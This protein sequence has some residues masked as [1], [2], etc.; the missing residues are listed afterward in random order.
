MADPAGTASPRAPATPWR[1][2]L[3]TLAW[4][5]LVLLGCAAWVHGTLVSLRLPLAGALQVLAGTALALAASRFPIR[6][7]RTDQSFSAA[8][9]FTVLLLLLHGPAAAGLAAAAEVL[10]T[11]W[12]GKQHWTA[13]VLEATGAALAMLLCGSL[14]QWLLPQPTGHTAAVLMAA[15]IFGGLHHAARSALALTLQGLRRARAPALD[16]LVGGFGWAGIAHAATAATAALLFIERQ[17]SG[18]VVML[19][20]VA[21]VALLFTT[22]HFF[23]LQQQADDAVRQ[24]AADAIER[25][26]EL[27]ASIARERAAALKAHHLRELEQSERRFHNAFTH[28]S[29]GM[30]LLHFDGRIRQ[31]NPALH[32]LL[33]REAVALE[34]QLFGDLLSPADAA[35][36]RQEMARV[37]ARE[38]ESLSLELC[39]R[40]RD[41]SE[42]WVS[43]NSS[44]FSEPGANEPCFILQIQDISARRRAEHELRHRAFHDK[45]TGL[46]NRERFNEVLCAALAAAQV[47]PQRRFAVLFLD[48]DRFKLINDSQGHAA[49][50]EFLVRAS[51]RLHRCLRHRDTLARLGG[52][53]F[54]IL[55]D[56]LA[57]DADA[58][59]L[60]ERLLEC[61][62]EPLGLAGL[63]VT[64][65][66]SIG[67]TFSSM[68]YRSPEDMLRDAD[69]AMYRAKVDG[70]ARFALFDVRLHTE[71]SNRLRLEA[72]LRDALAQRQLT[73]AYQP[74]FELAT[75]R[76]QGF[77]ALARWNH[78]TLGPVSP[79][80]FIP[81]AEESGLVVQLTDFV[82]D[83]ACRQLRQWQRANPDFDEI[84]LHVNVAAHDVAGGGLVTRVTEALNRTGLLPR[85]LTIELTENI[86]M[87]QLASALGTLRQL[88]ELGVGLAVDDFGTGYSSLSHLSV[89]PI[90]S[91]KIDMSFVRN[92]RVGSSEA[93][94]IRAIVLL[95]TSLGKRVIAEGI[96]TRSQQEQLRDL[97][98]ELGQGF[99]LSRPL[100]PAAVPHLL[101][102]A[103]TQPVPLDPLHEHAMD[104]HIH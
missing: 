1:G 93:A 79:G 55:A 64:A 104:R 41:G 6:L 50:D 42:V 94:V 15:M 97:G 99:Y 71:V 103:P 82:L 84:S 45:L 27:A 53:E 98:C 87:T 49:G 35:L 44:L 68:G 32:A 24:A 16:E 72:D 86:L 14:L 3:A 61:L 52:D 48:F 25:E 63:A 92:L 59:V 56:D 62:R 81:I 88:R 43:A 30:A 19:A 70:K 67:I 38:T 13:P 78:P 47:D 5:T 85:H 51:G 73:V 102:A 74:L 96:E 31:A 54:A 75:G 33:G 89:L 77:E 65:S 76:L 8:S 39:C 91:L 7:S 22:L 36:L 4:Y 58:V 17:H 29:I 28:A 46:P 101:N 34:S 23:T 83:T 20:M 66:A 40:H 2:R 60:A 80:T 57:D 37:A 10:G 9:I 11:R 26:A 21:I 18:G 95:G 12:R 90:D 100:P 69:I